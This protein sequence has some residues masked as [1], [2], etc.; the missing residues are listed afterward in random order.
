MR[1][2]SIRGVRANRRKR[3]TMPGE[4]WRIPAQLMDKFFERAAT[5]QEVMQ[6]V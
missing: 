1:E 4:G 5:C 3:T 6:A 2:L